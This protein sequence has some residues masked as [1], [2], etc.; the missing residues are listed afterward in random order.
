MSNIVSVKTIDNGQTYDLGIDHQDHQFYLSN[1]V[2]TS[3]SHAVLYSMISYHTAYLK[4]HFP[5]EFLMANLMDEIKSNS[6]KAEANIQKIKA[7]IRAHNVKIVPPDLNKSDIRYTLHGSEL[8]TGLDAIKFVSDDAI[9]D[10]IS[11]RPFVSFQDFILRTD[12]RKV[13]ANTVQALASAGCLDWCDI[14]RHL[15]Y[16]YCSDYRK[17]LTV[18]LKRHTIDEKFEYQWPKDKD[19]S[20]PQTYAMEHR[21]LGEGFICLPR[22]AYGT[23]FN[24][25]SVTINE[26]KQ[27]P[28]RT[29]ISS[30]VGIVKDFFEFRV[31]KETSRYYGKSM[32]KA[33]IE[34]GNGT[35]CGLTVFPDKWEQV[36][37]RIEQVGMKTAFESGIALHFAGTSNVY[38]DETGIILERLY[39]VHPIPQCPSKADLKARKVSMRL[40]RKVKTTKKTSKAI[41]EDVE[42]QLIVEGLIDIEET[43]ERD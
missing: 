22:I 19:W 30:I 43:D 35:H 9:N 21:Y 34:D 2:L 39:A 17:K 15:I 40:P 6:P 41:F 12:S 32:I 11:K 18:W 14:P 1:G 5:I 25:R 4:A 8:M 23:F 24:T 38:E 7:E 20:I 27:K 37:K 33:V 31:K 28:D 16:L 29:E 26:I 42:D 13:R 10:I 36:Q 3:N